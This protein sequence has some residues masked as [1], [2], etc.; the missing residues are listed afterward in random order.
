MCGSGVSVP[1][2]RGVEHQHVEPAP[3]RADG[4]GEAIDGV[5]VGKVERR[6]GGAAAGAVDAAFHSGEV[7]FVA[8]R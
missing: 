3:A 2:M 5:A 6:D 7:L 8:R 4:G 1:S